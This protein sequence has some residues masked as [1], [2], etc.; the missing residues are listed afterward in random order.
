MA[1]TPN[2]I[3]YHKRLIRSYERQADDAARRLRVAEDD[4]RNLERAIENEKVILRQEGV[5]I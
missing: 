1:L 2:D 4:V 5:D 3:A